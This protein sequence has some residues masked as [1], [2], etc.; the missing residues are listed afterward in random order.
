M[1][2]E[3]FVSDLHNS[4]RRYFVAESN[5]IVVG[6]G[7]TVRH[8]RS[9]DASPDA[10]PSGYFLA[11]VLV[12]R[13]YRRAGIGKSLTSARLEALKDE[14]NLVFYLADPKNEVTIALHRHFGFEEIR[15]VIRDDVR[16]L[17][18]RLDTGR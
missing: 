10:S 13:E 4:S 2:H 1:W 3:R 15:S 9:V 5:E 12:A 6:Y 16:Y 11:G 7:H 18:F 8:E 14:T 17:L